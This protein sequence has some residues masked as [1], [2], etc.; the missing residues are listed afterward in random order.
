MKRTCTVV[1]AVVAV[2]V[3][4]EQP[5]NDGT[6]LASLRPA[7]PS[8]TGDTGDWLSQDWHSQED[9]EV[10]W[11]PQDTLGFPPGSIEEQAEDAGLDILLGYPQP[12]SPWLAK[13]QPP[14]RLGS[15]VDLYRSVAHG[16]SPFVPGTKGQVF[17]AAP[18][19]R[20][21]RRPAACR[22][23]PFGLVCWNAARRGTVMRQRSSQFSQ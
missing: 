23:G 19:R 8:A 16:L 22:F 11:G 17:S 18:E 13:R 9:D 20:S 6:W 10:P 7:R 21:G 14:R 5:S 4:V 12:E 1:L 3:A 15:L 2:S